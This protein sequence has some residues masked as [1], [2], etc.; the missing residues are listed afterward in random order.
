MI[1][2]IG[3]YA[4]VLA[5]ALA[6]VQST[7]PLWGVWRGDVALMATARPV[8]VAQFL[9]IALSFAALTHAYLISD[10]SLLNVV[11]NSHSAKPLIY[12][13]SGVWGNHE[14]SMLLWVLILALFGALV[15][16]GSR[17]M[18]VD[19]AAATLAVQAWIGAALQR[20]WRAKHAAPLLQGVVACQH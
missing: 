10:F 11:E 16:L 20:S 18:P 12:K 7:A 13:I 2:E 6:I 19:L 17:A 9:L 15:A 5:L 1:T 3:H 4:L 8:A 14:G